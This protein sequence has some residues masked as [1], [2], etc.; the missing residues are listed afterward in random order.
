MPAGKIQQLDIAQGIGHR[1]R[2]V[3]IPAARRIAGIG[4]VGEF[5][6]AVGC[7]EIRD[8]VRLRAGI[9][10]GRGDA[11]GIGYRRQPLACIVGKL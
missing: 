6:N 1:Q 2:A 10:E 5:R 3:H 4:N 7:R 11:Y 9:G 8:K